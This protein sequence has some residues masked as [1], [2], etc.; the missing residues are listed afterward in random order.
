MTTPR[1]SCVSRRKLLTG[2]SVLLGSVT[3]GMVM[4]ARAAKAPSATA[5]AALLRKYKVPAVSFATFDRGGLVLC[6]AHGR[7]Q[8]ESAKVTTET[9]F[10]AASLSKTVNAL[11]VLNSFEMAGSA[12]TIR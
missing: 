11:C 6:A 7:R 3:G 4:P 12:S 5:I 9:R 8:V 10:Q 1:S 2:A